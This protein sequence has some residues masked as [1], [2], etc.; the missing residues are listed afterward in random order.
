LLDPNYD[1]RAFISYS[2]EDQAQA[3]RLHRALETYRVPRG[4]AADVGPDRRLGRFFRDDDEIGATANIGE[5]V[6]AAIRGAESLVVLCSPA[7]AKSAWVN[8]EILH[9]R[10]TG[11]GDRIFAVIIDGVP[12]SGDP[13]TE[14]YPPALRIRP[15]PPEDSDTATEPTGAGSMPMEPL[16]LYFRREPFA[17]L[18]TRLV[19][20]LLGIPFDALWQREQRRQRRRRLIVAGLGLFVLGLGAAAIFQYRSAREEQRRNAA[21]ERKHLVDRLEELEQRSTFLANQAADQ[22]D[23]V[24]AAL[25]ALETW[26]FEDPRPESSL[27]PFLAAEGP[28]ERIARLESKG[29]GEGLENPSHVFASA[30]VRRNVARARE[31]G[32]LKYWRDSVQVA[33]ASAGDVVALG[34]ENGFYTAVRLAD[35]RRLG[36]GQHR[37]YVSHLFFSDDDA[38]LVSVS[39]EKIEALDLTT[40][41]TAYSRPIRAILD[42]VASPDRAR[43]AVLDEDRGVEIVDLRTGEV[44]REVPIPGRASEIA[45]TARGEVLVAADEVLYLSFVGDL[46]NRQGK[47]ISFDHGIEKVVTQAGVNA[48]A[49]LEDGGRITVFS[50]QPER[51]VVRLS[52]DEISFATEAVLR[53]DVDRLYVDQREEVVVW[54]L[55]SATRVPITQCEAGFVDSLVVSS[56]HRFLA[57]GTRDGVICVWN[58]VDGSRVWRHESEASAVDWLGFSADERR[59]STAHRDGSFRTWAWRETSSMTTRAS[60][61]GDLTAALFDRAGEFLY[62][63]AGVMGLCRWPVDD[64]ETVV[65]RPSFRMSFMLIPFSESNERMIVTDR[66]GRVVELVAESLDVAEIYGGTEAIFHDG[67]YSLDGS[68]VVGMAID[69]S[70]WVWPPGSS[71]PPVGLAKKF[72]G[73]S[74]RV[75]SVDEDM[76]MICVVDPITGGYVFSG[77]TGEVLV[78]FDVKEK[79]IGVEFR[80]IDETVVVT[81]EGGSTYRYPFDYVLGAPGRVTALDPARRFELLRSELPPA[82]AAFETTSFVGVR[83]VASGRPLMQIEKSVFPECVMYR[84]VLSPSL[85]HLAAVLGGQGCPG[86]PQVAVW[87]VPEI[88]S[89]R[90]HPRA[91]KDVLEALEA[92]GWEDFYYL[93]AFWV[94]E[95]EDWA[96]VNGAKALHR[97]LSP[98]ERELFNLGPDPPCWCAS[99]RFPSI[100]DWREALGYDPFLEERSDGF[101]CRAAEREPWR[102]GGADHE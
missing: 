72:P 3:A 4:I 86:G 12:N 64:P 44:E 43:I 90:L 40:G 46:E 66:S 18:Q 15:E 29:W 57:A 74:V 78:F 68:A 5:S 88:L 33:M 38:L 39:D 36:D 76:R 7:A 8:A 17:R 21:L 50:A 35:G 26:N 85:R 41:A 11:R 89:R 52:Q 14:C 1:Y 98:S 49:V 99:K 32:Y 24:V 71:D 100:A 61:E 22:D 30:E 53:D 20:G 25:L 2:S 77:K 62:G 92:G 81:L 102:R 10:R 9:F 59:L 16:G 60:C 84:A 19:A 67:G 94:A 37:E 45:W 51:G 28:R 91:D 101:T 27:A 70:L 23:P 79:I 54:D 69:G 47:K 6:R 58:T 83:D 87:P 97:C 73:R 96:F 34:Y 42:A 80:L 48:L 65:H 95:S 31:V 55:A 63:R 93:L 75:Y 82:L 56:S 13:A